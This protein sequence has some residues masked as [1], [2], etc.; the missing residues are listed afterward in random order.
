[1]LCKPCCFHIKI[2]LNITKTAA[3]LVESPKTL[4]KIQYFNILG[5]K[6]QYLLKEACFLRQVCYCFSLPEFM[7]DFKFPVF[8]HF[9]ALCALGLYDKI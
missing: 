6:V 2:G 4:L 3:K 7:H 8:V 5:A 9:F 1:M